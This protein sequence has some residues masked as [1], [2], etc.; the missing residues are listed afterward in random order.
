MRLSAR[1]DHRSVRLRAR[2]RR[3]LERDGGHQG[4][5]RDSRDR[6]L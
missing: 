6:G 1:L 4:V 2:D 5:R 3:G